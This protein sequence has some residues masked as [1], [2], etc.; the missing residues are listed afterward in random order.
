MDECE[1]C[2]ELL[3][4]DEGYVTDGGTLC[5]AECYDSVVAGEFYDDCEDETLL[6]GYA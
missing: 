3:D 1:G 2:G 5:C 6:S 4:D